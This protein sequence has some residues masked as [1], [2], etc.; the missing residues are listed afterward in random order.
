MRCLPVRRAAVRS[1][2]CGYGVG[3]LLIGLVV[4]L[5]YGVGVRPNNSRG[6][7]LILSRSTLLDFLERF[8]LT[9][10][11]SGDGLPSDLMLMGDVDRSIGGG[12]WDS[13]CSTLGSPGN[14]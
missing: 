6:G 3:V 14:M 5:G 7:V 9:K 12:D 8:S 13:T 10:P 1:G 4:R 2:Q 11:A